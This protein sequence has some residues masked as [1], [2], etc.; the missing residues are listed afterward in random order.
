G[1]GVID[2]GFHFLDT[3]Q[4]FYGEPE[5]V[6]A[7]VRAYRDGQT[8]VARDGIAEERENTLMAIYTFKSGVIG[9]WCWSWAVAG[10]ETRD[11][12]I[13]GSEGSIEDTFYSNRFMVYHQFMDGGELRRRDGTFLSM[14][15]LQAKHRREIGP[16][17][18][19]RLFPNGITDHFAIEI[20]D[21]LDAIASDRPPEVDGWGGLA[22]LALVEATYESSWSG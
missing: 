16:E 20:W 8:V 3:I 21:F 5:Q 19:Q 12:V 15:E 14:E 10:R 13:N 7:E 1:A 9:T 22:T 4:Y 6:Y 2:S 11:C 17:R 18:V